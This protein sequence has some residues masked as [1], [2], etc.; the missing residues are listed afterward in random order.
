VGTE[1]RARHLAFVLALALTLVLSAC[2]NSQVVPRL[3]GDRYEKCESG[4]AMVVWE[5]ANELLEGGQHTAAIPLL[6]RCIELCPEHVLYHVRYMDTAK[7]LPPI[8]KGDE[9]VPAAATLLMREYYANFQDDGE[10]P[11]APYFAARLQRFE[12]REAPAQELLSTA[13]KRD[14]NFYFAHYERGLLWRGIGR[15]HRAATHLRRALDAR[16]GFLDARRELADCYAELW[17]WKRAA[18]QYRI[19]LEANPRDRVAQRAYLTLIVYRVDGRLAEASQLVR[20]LLASAPE[21]L[22][23]QMDL[24]AVYWKQ[25]QLAV[26]ADTYRQVLQVDHGFAR[27]AL[28]LGN[29]HYD[30]GRRSKGTERRDALIKSRFAY[31]YFRELGRSDD[32]YDW[33]DLMLATRARLREID[34]ELG[35]RHK[36]RVIW[37]DL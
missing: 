18:D 4:E 37:S 22:S 31:R 3:F 7:A 27:A 23:L 14:S 8:K 34:L 6:R 1:A 32:A 13:L 33:F 12:K 28:N 11:L 21:D 20:A 17:E 19:Y 15:S 9:L 5:R 36:E 2:M 35:A 16:P 29:L 25:G 10:S 30:L 24:A 26:A